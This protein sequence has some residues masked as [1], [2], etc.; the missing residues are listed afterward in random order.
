MGP[1]LEA[2]TTGCRPGRIYTGKVNSTKPVSTAHPGFISNFQLACT[3]PNMSL[4]TSLLQAIT[5]AEAEF[6]G[7]GFGGSG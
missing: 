1:Y 4:G 3:H 7:R 2:E 5:G 6:G